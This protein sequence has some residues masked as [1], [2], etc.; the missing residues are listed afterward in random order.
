MLRHHNIN[1]NICTR[2]KISACTLWLMDLYGTDEEQSR[3]SL[4]QDHEITFS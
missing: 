3:Q 1:L 2:A 4:E